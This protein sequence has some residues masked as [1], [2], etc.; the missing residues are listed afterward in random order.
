MDFTRTHFD[1]FS[2][3]LIL[4]SK[5]WLC[6]WYRVILLRN[7]H[8]VLW[9]GGRLVDKKEIQKSNQPWKEEDSLAQSNLKCW[10]LK[11]S[12][13]VKEKRINSSQNENLACHHLVTTIVIQPP[14]R[15]PH[16]C[17]GWHRIKVLH[18]A[19]KC[20]FFPQEAHL[21]CEAYFQDILILTSTITWVGIIFHHICFVPH[22]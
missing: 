12:W 16:K 10:S 1:I 8:I 7:L 6:I 5:L 11:C 4:H 19:C 20:H 21:Y 3:N 14:S 18:Y 22:W 17:L 9:G 13:I 2:K 15:S